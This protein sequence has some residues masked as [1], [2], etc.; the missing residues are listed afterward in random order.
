MKKTIRLIVIAAA[1]LAT[2]NLA[3]ASDGTINFT[4]SVVSSTCK[5]SGGSDLSVALPKA[6]TSQFTG[7]GS[8]AGRTPFKLTVSG[9]ATDKAGEGGTVSAPVKKVSIAFEPGPNVDIGTGRLNLTGTD[10]AKGIQIAVL[11]DK[12]EDIKLGAE[13]SAQNV[14]T[15]AI[16]TAVGGTG[17]ATLQ[18]AAQYVATSDT[19]TAGSANSFVTYSLVYP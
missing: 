10:A 17:S 1:P 18:F 4:G 7:V 15:V 3:H 8:T 13:S 14:Q 9:C 5:V 6:S 12:Y 11:N 2:V 16:D 19:V